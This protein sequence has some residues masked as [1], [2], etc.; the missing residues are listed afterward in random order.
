MQHGVPR[1]SRVAYCIAGNT[2]GISQRRVIDGFR[3]NVIGA[4]RGEANVFLRLKLSAQDNV[5]KLRE[6]IARRKQWTCSLQAATRSEWRLRLHTDRAHRLHEVPKHSRSQ[7][8]LWIDE[9]ALRW[10]AKR[11]K[12]AV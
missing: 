3:E 10:C 11:S 1:R 9:R 2:R 7:R 5:A 12:S 6:A 8:S 4:F